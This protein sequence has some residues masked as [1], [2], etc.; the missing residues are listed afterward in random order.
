MLSKISARLRKREGFTL[1]E[2]LVVVAI[3]GLLATLAMPRVFESIKKAKK[4]QGDADVHTI[5]T[6]LEQVFMESSNSAYPTAN[7]NTA[8]TGTGILKASAADLKNEFGNGYV[9]VTNS[10]GGFFAII[11]PHDTPDGDDIVLTCGAA[12]SATSTV[13]NDDDVATGLVVKADSTITAA[14]V[15]AN[16]CTAENEGGA[17]LTVITN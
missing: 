3:I 11:D 16:T 9:Y 8:I 6:A 2:L 5:S 15:K 12:A 17:E 1:I 10:T 4:A 7:V 14:D 13:V